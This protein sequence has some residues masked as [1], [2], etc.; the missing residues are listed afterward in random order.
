MRH[1]RPTTRVAT[2][3]ALSAAVLLAAVPAHAA[4]RGTCARAE[5]PWRMT[6]PDGSTRE[7]GTLALCLQQMYNPA[8][9]LHEIRLDGSP[10]G[11]FPSHAGESEGLYSDHRPVLIFLRNGAGEHTL[12][13]YAV[14]H[15]ETMQTY[16]LHT[17]GRQPAVVAS[18][19]GD[20][21]GVLEVRVAAMVD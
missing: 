12:V 20:R 16:M 21:A 18:A 14:P 11:M 4:G 6:L 7:A 3:V 15:G 13:G 10:V 1:V 8:A 5:I 17:F 2:V 9:G 19:R